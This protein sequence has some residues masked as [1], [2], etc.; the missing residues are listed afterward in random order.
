MKRIRFLFFYVLLTA[1]SHLFACAVP[2]FRYALERWPPDAFHLTLL[3]KGMNKEEINAWL[4]P[5]YEA[6]MGVLELDLREDSLPEQ[7]SE[8]MKVLATQV[9]EQSPRFLLEYPYEYNVETPI[10]SEVVSD[11]QRNLILRSPVRDEIVKRLLGGHST[12]WVFIPGTDETANRELK[13]LLEAGIRNMNETL[14]LPEKMLAIYSPDMQE[15]VRKELPIHFS[16]LE[17]DREDP[18]ELILTESLKLILGEEEWSQKDKAWVMPV[19]GQGR[20]LA[21]EDQTTFTMEMLQDMSSFLTGSCSCEVKRLNP[22]FDVF[23]VEAWMADLA[24]SFVEEANQPPELFNPLSYEPE[25]EEEIQDSAKKIPTE[26][27]VTPTPTPVVAVTPT[28][29]ISWGMLL[30]G[31][32][33]LLLA[34]G[35]ALWKAG[36]GDA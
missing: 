7:A 29:T 21:I 2:V 3:H 9:T 32:L 18:Q 13:A 14:E 15:E 36:T 25:T 8:R 6:H 26:E 33:V 11:E 16:M 10:L 22:G 35:V 23:I 4:D 30:G 20:A 5:V 34:T 19:F 17:L 27:E 12:V 1:S 28:N 31:G 24:R